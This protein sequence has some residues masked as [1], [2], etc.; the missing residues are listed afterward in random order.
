MEANGN[1]DLRLEALLGE[2][3]RKAQA[4]L[5][6]QKQFRLGVLPIEQANPKT[7][8]LAE[9]AQKDPE[10]A[11][12]MLQAVDRDVEAVADRG[13]AS[14]EFAQLLAAMQRT[15]DQGGRICFSGCGATGRLSILLEASWR[16]FWQDLR[17]QHRDVAARLPNL[18]DRV[19]SIMTGGD[20]ALVRSVENFEDYSVFGRRQVQEAHLGQGDILVGFTGTAETTSVLGTLW[21][22]VDD[23]AETFLVFNTP[24]DVAARH[25]ERARQ[26][27]EDP[28]IVKLCLNNGP[29]AVTGSTRMQSTSTQLL[30]VGAALEMAL[31]A[32]L[33]SQ[34]DASALKQLSIVPRSS[35]DYR[36]GFAEL[37]EDLGQPQAVATMA[38]WIRY[39]EEVYRHKGLVTYLADECL[40]DIFTDTTERSPTFMLPRFRTCDDEVSPPS[41]AFVKNPRLPTPEAWRQVLRRQPRCLAWDSRTYREMD[42]P[43]SLQEK[44]PHLDA[45]EML[46]FLIGNEDD[47]SRHRGK[48]DAAIL[49]ILGDEAE[50]LA[51]ADDPLRQAFCASASPFAHRVVLTLGPMASSPD[52]ALAVWHL[53]VRLSKSLLRLGDRMVVKLVLNTVSTLTAARLGRL[54]G[55]SM[56]YL[57]PSNKKLVDR[58]TRLIAEQAGVDYE[59]AC[60]ALHETMEELPHMV[61]PGEE[62]PSPVAVAIARLQQKKNK[63]DAL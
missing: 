17:S 36:R 63:A 51:R 20:Y 15:L 6:H 43:I 2:A 21:Q 4:F 47:S 46:K 9:T 25:I 42:A 1:N 53:P 37:M 50:R 54:V 40:L 31:V 38:A 34:L 13:F 24:A 29:M 60:F 22:A 28:R 61:K 5:D 49:I 59:T 32:W 8:W 11:I 27:I 26:V 3:R 12:R 39:E 14:P 52:S 57:N 44:P 55:N 45:G 41:W 30:V 10:A 58:G 18:E 48:D 62:L 33:G 19:V 7:A 16:R 23:G 35:A 56:A